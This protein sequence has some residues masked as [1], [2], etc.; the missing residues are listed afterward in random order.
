VIPFLQ[1]GVF[2]GTSNAREMLRTGEVSWDG[3]YA[4]LSQGAGIW[5]FMGV[6]VALFLVSTW[7]SV[8]KNQK[9]Y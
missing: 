6:S 8:S 9:F 5:G 3:V 1:L 4:V 2:L 7:V